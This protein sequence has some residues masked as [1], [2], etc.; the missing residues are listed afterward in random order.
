MLFK[1]EQALQIC[2][3]QLHKTV[4]Q[5]VL[6]CDKYSWDLSQSDEILLEVLESKMLGNTRKWTYIGHV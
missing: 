2:I 4:T 6:V 1:T 5:P 3:I